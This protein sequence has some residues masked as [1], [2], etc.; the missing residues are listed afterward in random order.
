MLLRIEIVKGTRKHY[1]MVKGRCFRAVA[2]EMSDCVAMI[3]E[4]RTWLMA[5]NRKHMPAFE[6][7]QEFNLHKGDPTKFIRVAI[8]RVGEEE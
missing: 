5:G 8:R 1:G 3:I 4:D 6:R 7:G 2:R